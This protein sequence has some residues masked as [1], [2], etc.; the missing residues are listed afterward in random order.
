MKNNMGMNAARALIGQPRKSFGSDANNGACIVAFPETSEETMDR[1]IPANFVNVTEKSTEKTKNSTTTTTATPYVLRTTS[2][3]WKLKAWSAGVSTGT[4]GGV[5]GTTLMKPSTRVEVPITFATPL[6]E[7][8]KEAVVE[9]FCAQTKTILNSAISNTTLVTCSIEP[10]YKLIADIEADKA[11]ID[12]LK[13]LLT[14]FKTEI[15]TTLASD[16]E[17]TGANG[18]TNVEVGTVDTT[19]QTEV[20]DTS[21]IDSS[22]PTESPTPSPPQISDASVAMVSVAS[23]FGALLF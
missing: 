20:Q 5:P 2:I 15:G 22:A 23:I 10:G 16:P 3:T 1:W 9:A 17:I 7:E 19:E 4:G 11:S 12:A 13:L 6:T 21:I 18:G 14:T 8:Q